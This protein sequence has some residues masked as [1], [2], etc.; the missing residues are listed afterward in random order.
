MLLSLLRKASDSWRVRSNSYRHPKVKAENVETAVLSERLSQGLADS[1]VLAVSTAADESNAAL[2]EFGHTLDYADRGQVLEKSENDGIEAYYWIGVILGKKKEFEIAERALLRVTTLRPHHAQAWNNLGSFALRRGDAESAKKAFEL[3]IA[4]NPEL[5]EPYC[6]LGVLH[7]EQGDVLGAV[8]Y[9]ERAEQLSPHD[10]VL[11][12][13]LAMARW[14][15]GEYA[16]ARKTIRNCLERN[17]DHAD[18]KYVESFM[19]LA[20]GE[21]STGWKG[22]KYRN[23]R[24]TMPGHLRIPLWCGEDLKGRTILVTPE[25]GLGE[26]IIFGSCIPDLLN[27]DVHCIFVCADKLKELFQRTFPAVVVLGAG[28]VTLLK[29]F[30]PIDFQVSIADLGSIFRTDKRTILR[31]GAYLKVDPV[32]VELWR[33]DLLKLGEGLKVGISWKGGSPKTGGTARSIPLLDWSPIL[34]V[35]P[36]HFINLQYGDCSEEIT[37]IE[38]V[39]GKKIISLPVAHTNLYR[40]AELVSALDLVICVDTSLA[41]LCAGLGKAAWILLPTGPSWPYQISEPSSP[42]FPSAKFYRMSLPQDWREPI[43]RVAKDLEQFHR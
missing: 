26:Q 19:A 37:K 24:M 10:P 5:Y 31:G 14:E 42:W 25:Q 21:F 39:L 33:M 4:I 28:E 43:E 22:Y 35:K 16:H 6:N 12:C 8:R 34:R 2:A 38:S 27:L 41:Y 36:V 30:G 11:L 40:T 9:F 1:L 7:H 32:S 18:A 17:Q 20:N 3:A 23:G 29:S 15:R 13:N